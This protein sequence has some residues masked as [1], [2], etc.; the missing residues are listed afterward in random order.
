MYPPLRETL[1]IMQCR[2]IF[3]VFTCLALG[4]PCL[5]F[6]FYYFSSYF[7]WLFEVSCLLL[8]VC[9]M[10]SVGS[11]LSQCIIESIV[12]FCAWMDTRYHKNKRYFKISY[13]FIGHE[14]SV[15]DSSQKEALPQKEGICSGGR[16]KCKILVV[17]ISVMHG[18][19]DIFNYSNTFNQVWYA[20]F[21]FNF[22]SGSSIY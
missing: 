14:L 6:S 15:S 18:Q 7:P 12:R 8:S 13:R 2:Q 20:V 1:L 5:S 3:T 11:E 21:Q 16:F 17:L 9:F 19:E 4:C 22:F 10:Q